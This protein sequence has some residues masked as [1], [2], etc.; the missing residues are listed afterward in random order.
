[1]KELARSNVSA[2]TISRITVM[3]PE[4]FEAFVQAVSAPV[5]EMVASLRRKARW[6]KGAAKR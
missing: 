2:A 5:P 1:M 3:S 4:G 6:E